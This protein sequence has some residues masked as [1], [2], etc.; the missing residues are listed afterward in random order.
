[1]TGLKYALSPRTSIR[2]DVAEQTASF[3][4]GQ[5]PAASTLTTALSFGRQ[6]TRSQSVG[7]S[8]TFQDAKTTGTTDTNE[9][10][11][12]TWQQSIGR[13]VFVDAAAGMRLYT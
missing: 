7:V 2:W 9:G 6:L 8:A 11:F 10:V 5:L 13:D 4:G 12:G 1:S 3:A